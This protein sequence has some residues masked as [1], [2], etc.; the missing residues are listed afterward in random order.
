MAS[1][2]MVAEHATPD[3]GNA[4]QRADVAGGRMLPIGVGEDSIAE[5]LMRLSGAPIASKPPN[6]NI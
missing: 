1:G 3:A 6:H 4:L 5:L 2:W